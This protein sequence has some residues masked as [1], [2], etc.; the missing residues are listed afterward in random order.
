MKALKIGIISGVICIAA[1]L[2]VVNVVTPEQL[3]PEQIARQQVYDNKALVDKA[4]RS[5]FNASALYEGSKVTFI[6]VSA[7]I[8]DEYTVYI[9]GTMP[10]AFGSHVKKRGTCLYNLKEDIA[11]LELY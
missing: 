6:L 8:G 11:S 9:S 4:C 7:P 10:N 2:I 3:T 1:I 5:A